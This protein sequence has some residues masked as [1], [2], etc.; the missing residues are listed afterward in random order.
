MLLSLLQGDTLPLTLLEPY[1]VCH[2]FG[3]SQKTEEFSHLY[4]TSYNYI[5]EV[6]L[7]F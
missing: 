2:Y 3:K 7:L 1:Y 5:I 4:L 6:M